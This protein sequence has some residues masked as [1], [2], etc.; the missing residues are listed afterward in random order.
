M[1]N[2]EKTEYPLIREIRSAIA[3]DGRTTYA[4]A[5][6]SG[7]DEASI[8]RFVSR[9]RSLSLESADRLAC[10]LGLALVRKG[11]GRKV[12]SVKES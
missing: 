12:A 5:K 1:K 2:P 7:V 3:D 11:R 4:L 8:R 6:D 9:E 10:A